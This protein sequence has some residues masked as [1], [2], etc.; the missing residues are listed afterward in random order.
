MAAVLS[1]GVAVATVLVMCGVT[2]YRRRR[3]MLKSR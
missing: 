1:T 3:A 2:W